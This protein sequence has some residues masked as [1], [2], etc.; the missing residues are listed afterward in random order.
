MPVKIVGL[1]WRGGP[2]THPMDIVNVP[3]RPG[4]YKIHYREPSG[5]WRIIKV[6]EAQNLYEALVG[7]LSSAET[8]TRLRARIATGNCAY[9]YAE[10]PDEGERKAA[11]RALY[12]HFQPELNDPAELPEPQP[13]LEFN[14]N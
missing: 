4:V 11:L 14:P 6:G 1:D 12:D 10:L 13:G 5:E 2:Y 8:D 9:S 7:H 3:Q